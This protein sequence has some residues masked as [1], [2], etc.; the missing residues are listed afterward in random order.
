MEDAIGTIACFF[1]PVN[2]LA[3]SRQIETLNR[4]KQKEVTLTCRDDSP[5]HGEEAHFFPVNK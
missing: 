2:C 3:Y 1:T 5:Q 4:F